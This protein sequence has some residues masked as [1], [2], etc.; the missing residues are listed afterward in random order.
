VE[1]ALTAHTT[2]LEVRSKGL[3]P[4][5]P[6]VASSLVSIASLH[7]KKGDVAK[8]LE[9]SQ[10]ALAIRRASLPPND[11]DIARSLFNIGLYLR[12]LG[13]NE[14][15]LPVYVEAEGALALHDAAPDVADALVGQAMAAHALKRVPEAI[16]LYLRAAE[17]RRKAL[18][19]LKLEVAAALN[20]AAVLLQGEKRVEEALAAFKEV[21]DIRRAALGPK[22]QDLAVALTHVGSILSGLLKHAE[23]ADAY[24]EVCMSVCVHLFPCRGCA[25][26]LCCRVHS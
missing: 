1:D 25:C 18:G 2:A 26:V 10:Q 23:A 3:G 6:S 14:E 7:C 20:S 9:V 5:H 8:A 15:A 21:A 16:H 13:R 12:K 4:S 24:R 17:V 11:M 19:P 22:H